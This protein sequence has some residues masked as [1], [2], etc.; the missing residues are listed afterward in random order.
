MDRVGDQQ[1]GALQHLRQRRDDLER[2]SQLPKQAGNSVRNTSI[3][4]DIASVIAF[5]DKVGV[6]WSD[7]DS[8]PAVANDGYYFSAIAVDADP[9]VEANWSFEK[10]PTLLPSASESA[11]NH[12]NIKARGDGTLYMV[13]KT[14]KDTA[15]CASN[16]NQP[17]IEFFRRTTAG[18]STAHLVG[19][20]GD[21][22]T[23]AQLVISEQLNTAWVFLTSP[24]GGGAIYRKSAHLSGPGALVF[25]GTADTTIQRGAPFIRSATETSIDDPTTTKQPVTAASGIV[26]LA[27]NLGTA[28]QQKV[29]LHNEMSI[30]ATDATAPASARSR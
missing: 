17:L 15:N 11:D 4:G 12:I 14:G 6:A 21:C 30:A 28:G 22:N 20:A 8:L 9:T 5:G 7:H 25:R 10:L 23:R 16:L 24:N 19:T 29:Y 3:N 27:N 26:V 2:S 1:P 13:G 18:V